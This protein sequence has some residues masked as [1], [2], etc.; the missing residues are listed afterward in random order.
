MG[1]SQYRRTVSMRPEV[2]LRAQALA[3]VRATS[4]TRLVEELVERACAAAGVP[5]I[6]RE[7]AR[8]AIVARP[9]SRS[10]GA[11]RVDREPYEGSPF[12][13]VNG[14]RS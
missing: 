13:I 12:D 8:A 10:S 3:E 11:R 7:T 9:K 6:D 14:V 5:E 2:Y 4:L 1:R